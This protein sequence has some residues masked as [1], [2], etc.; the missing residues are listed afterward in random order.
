SADLG[1]ISVFDTTAVTGGT[2][3]GVAATWD[4]ATSTLTANAGTALEG[5]SVR[6]TGDPVSGVVGSVVVGSTTT[7]ESVTIGGEAAD[8]DPLTGMIRGRTGSRFEGIELSY[9]AP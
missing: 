4:E 9:S 2:I 8:W 6:Y 5:L 3:G 7:L 1:D